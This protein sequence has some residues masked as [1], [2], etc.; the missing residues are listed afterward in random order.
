MHYCHFT[1]MFARG[2]ALMLGAGCI[3]SPTT[4]RSGCLPTWNCEMV[5]RLNTQS[6]L[7]DS[8]FLYQSSSMSRCVVQSW[9]DS[10]TGK[11]I[12]DFRPSSYVTIHHIKRVWHQVHAEQ[13]EE[14]NGVVNLIF[15]TVDSNQDKEPLSRA[16]G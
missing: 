16:H 4:N 12:S 2:N 14:F 8:C 1:L 15:S 10:T 6:V 7:G 9:M 11:R 3:A 5:L 13:L